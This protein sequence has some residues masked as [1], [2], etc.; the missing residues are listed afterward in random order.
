MGRLHLSLGL[1]LGSLALVPAT[2]ANAGPPPGDN[3]GTGDGGLGPGSHGDRVRTSGTRQGGREDA[4]VDSPSP[5]R[6]PSPSLLPWTT[7][8]SSPDDPSPP[9]KVHT[10]A[11]NRSAPR[12]RRTEAGHA[13]HPTRPTGHRRVVTRRR[14]GNRLGWPGTVYADKRAMSHYAARS[15]PLGR[16]GGRWGARR[17]K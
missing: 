12:P 1:G 3:M 16:P 13:R 6:V 17:R 15:T 14:L 8:A 2:P 11:G 5:G 7:R 9:P 10:R 4:R